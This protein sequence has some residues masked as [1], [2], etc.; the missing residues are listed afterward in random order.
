ML[1][2]CLNHR[3]VRLNLDYRSSIVVNNHPCDD[4][5][6]LHHTHELGNR[7]VNLSF[8]YRYRSVGKDVVDSKNSTAS[9]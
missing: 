7:F 2:V 8:T 6:S 3:I 4:E 1:A 5:E 9:D